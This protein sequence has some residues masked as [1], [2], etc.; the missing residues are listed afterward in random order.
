MPD[1]PQTEDDE[2][3]KIW[4]AR[5]AALARVLG[6]PGEMVFH[7][8]VPFQLGGFADVL[9]FPDYVP[10]AT[11]V[12]AEL[13]GEDVGQ[14]PSSLGHYEL[15]ICV[16]RDLPKAADLVSK[17]ARYT[18]DAE[19]E[20]GQ[21]MDVGAYFGD[22]TIRALVFTHPREEPVWFEFLGVRYGLLL[23]V[24]ITAK[25]L[26]FGRSQGTERLL[27]LLREHGVYPYTTP[28]RPS[29]PLLAGSIFG[30]I[31]GR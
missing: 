6:K 3:Q 27:A 29:V 28:D 4:D 30:R 7:A 26:A 18:C 25:E 17:L 13:T 5:S 21:T 15:M 10:G 19:V 8:P 23:C 12:T 31:F 16:R 14:R 1:Q 11:Y 9:P 2:W 20:A 24:G 22:S